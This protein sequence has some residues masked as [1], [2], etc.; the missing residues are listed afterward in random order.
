MGADVCLWDEALAL[1][2]A[3]ERTVWHEAIGRC[4]REL[5]SGQVSS[6]SVDYAGDWLGCHPTDDD[7]AAV[8]VLLDGHCITLVCHRSTLE[9]AEAAGGGAVGTGTEGEGAGSEEEG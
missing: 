7:D 6:H 2:E 4:E 3:Q 1:A 8:G 5:G 9:A